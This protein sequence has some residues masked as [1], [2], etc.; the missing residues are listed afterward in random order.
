LKIGAH[1]FHRVAVFANSQR[2][3]SGTRCSFKP[4][5]KLVQ[6]GE[7]TLIRWSRLLGDV[8]FPKGF[9]SPEGFD[10]GKVV[11]SLK[12]LLTFPFVASKQE[13]LG[14]EINNQSDGEHYERRDEEE[15]RG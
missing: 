11:L 6:R 4:V 15:A 9:G 14:D 2:D 5:Q 1:S 12:R 8:K 3:S 7:V 13:L 10:G